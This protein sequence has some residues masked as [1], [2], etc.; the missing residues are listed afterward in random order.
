MDISDSEDMSYKDIQPLTIEEFSNI[1]DAIFDVKK[2][3]SVSSKQAKEFFYRWRKFRN[4]Y[5][6][7]ENIVIVW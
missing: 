7:V 4:S 1:R 6:K 2:S 3:T 5:E